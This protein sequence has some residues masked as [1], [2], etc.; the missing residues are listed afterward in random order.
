M[1]TENNKKK[2]GQPPEKQSWTQISIAL[3]F[4]AAATATVA[5]GI[6]AG[7]EFAKSNINKQRTEVMNIVKKAGVHSF[8]KPSSMGLTATSTEGGLLD[9]KLEAFYTGLNAHTDEMCTVHLVRKTGF[10]GYK[11]G[12]DKMET[13]CGVDV[14]K[15]KL[16]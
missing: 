10:L 12:E 6:I 7:V 2:D 8:A 14:M 1:T 9:G 4:A 3:A 13:A 15:F 5:I 11:H 16:S